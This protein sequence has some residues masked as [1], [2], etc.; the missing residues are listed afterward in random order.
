MRK[1]HFLIA[2]SVFGLDRLTKRLIAH[3]L[4]LYDYIQVIPRLFRITHV[5]NRGAGLHTESFRG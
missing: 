5:E 2:L 3:N 1:Y 4:A